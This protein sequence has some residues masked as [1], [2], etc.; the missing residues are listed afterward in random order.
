MSNWID[1]GDIY[2]NEYQSANVYD[3]GNGYNYLEIYSSSKSVV[4][5]DLTKFLKIG[6]SYIFSFGLPT[7]DG[8]NSAALTSCN[9]LWYLVDG[10]GYSDGSYLGDTC[11]ELLI[12]N[13][14][15]SK[16]LGKKTSYEFT[17]TQGFKNTYLTLFRG[18]ITNAK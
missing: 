6:D 3:Y 1:F 7:T 18:S 17:Y 8:V 13:E 12:N 16:F 2:P 4:L 10:G 14:N 5:I 9:I 15:K 11:F